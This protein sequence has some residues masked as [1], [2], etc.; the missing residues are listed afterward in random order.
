L[1]INYYYDSAS[2]V[3]MAVS[4]MGW[5]PKRPDDTGKNKSPYIGT[6]FASYPWRLSAGSIEKVRPRPQ[7]SSSFLL[8]SSLELSD[9]TIHEPYIRALLGTAPHVCQ[10]VV[11]KLRPSTPDPQPQT[12]NPRPSAPDPQPQTLNPEPQTVNLNPKPSTLNP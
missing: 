12:L 4:N 9:T 11:L 1:Q 5:W 10:V 2:S 7:P 6:K 8:L 3:T